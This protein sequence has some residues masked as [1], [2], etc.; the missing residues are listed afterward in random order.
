MFCLMSFVLF[1][2]QIQLGIYYIFWQELLRVY[3][4]EQIL[5]LQ[6]DELRDKDTA[7]S[8]AFKFLDMSK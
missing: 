6:N 2:I 7:L 1:Q 3:P 5:A 8:K 4:R